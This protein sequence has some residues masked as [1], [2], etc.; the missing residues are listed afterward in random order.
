MN[1]RRITQLIAS[2]LF[3]LA[4]SP[5]AAQ[6][7][8]YTVSTTTDE[9]DGSPSCITGTST[10][11]SLREA[12]Q[13]ANANTSEDS[14]IV[15]PAGIYML[16]MSASGDED[17][18]ATGDLDIRNTS[19]KITI[20][21][22]A[23]A[24]TVIDGNGATMLTRVL[25]VD[26]ESSLT[27]QNLTIE[28][29]LLSSSSDDGGGIQN[30]G[31]LS[32]DTVIVKDNTVAGGGGGIYNGGTLV[33]T[34]TVV[35]HNTAGLFGGGIA[36]DGTATLTNS[37]ATLNTVTHA[38]SAPQGGGIY[39]GGTLTVSGSQITGNTSS[40]DTNNAY[41]GGVYN[42][43]TSTVTITN[44][45]IAT[46]TVNGKGT[47]SSDGIGGGLY[48]YDTTAS[49]TLVH[50]TI[51]SNTAEIGGGLAGPTTLTHS[52]L[53]DNTATTSDADCYGAQ[54]SG[55][56]NII[57][58]VSA[59]CTGLSSDTTNLLNTD[60]GLAAA[61]TAGTSTTDY[62]AFQL[63]STSPA[64]NTIPAAT[65]LTVLGTPTNDQLGIARRGYCDMG[66]YEYQDTVTP[67]ISITNDTSEYNIV[68]CTATYSDAS[69]LALDDI[70]GDISSLMTTTSLVNTAVVGS[71]TVTYEVNDLSNNTA[72]PAVRSVT[73]ADTTAPTV[74]VTGDNP[75]YVSLNATYTDAGATVADTC[76]TTVS[77]VTTNPVDTTTA[78]DYT[79]TYTSTDASGNTTTATRTVTVVAAITE[80]T[81]DEDGSLVVEDEEG[82]TTTLEPFPGETD[83]TFEVTDDDERIV[84]T[85]GKFVR[86]FVNGTR[87]AQKKINQKKLRSRF[88]TLT[89]KKLYRAKSYEAIMV[90]LA[91]P[92]T[93][94]VNHIRL[95]AANTLKKYHHKQ[96]E[97]TDRRPGSIKVK[98][99]K[100]RFI[101]RF[102]NGSKRVKST[103]KVTPKGAL[104]AI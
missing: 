66:S 13:L 56:Y 57:E 95:T 3:T 81:Q 80:V 51:T 33:L 55:G 21:G 17:N 72:T 101:T 46:N 7:T 14:T 86:V 87:V 34:S 35:T 49:S 83:Y 73:V 41:G 94:K 65:C 42:Y 9:L 62:Y 60:P 102:G 30:H 31:S 77:V 90:M 29:G 32:L 64:I 71:Y 15:L 27:L 2:T 20:Q 79:V 85:N 103:W 11:C 39:N 37:E 8:S 78:G 25:E 68:E 91:K 6:A 45:T 96:V 5:L 99:P 50:T 18:N 23:A 54:T 104:K 63:A 100:H 75:G 59:N 84:V 47:S 88:V 52:I 22:A 1:T 61:P 10:D 43:L 98:A 40:S 76:D 48:A 4:L 69:A 92:H 12:I 28:D 58:T 70:D 24:T 74:T 82:N 16:T 53:T 26:G 93:G 67:A 89:V 19:K 97:I 44:S 38:T 36:N